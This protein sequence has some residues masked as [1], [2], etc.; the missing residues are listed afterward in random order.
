MFSRVVG[1]GGNPVVNRLPEMVYRNGA[2]LAHQSDGSF[3]LIAELLYVERIL[4]QSPHID[5][6][7]IQN[8]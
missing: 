4:T 8:V 2:V 7:M 1:S 3:T 5:K 6:I